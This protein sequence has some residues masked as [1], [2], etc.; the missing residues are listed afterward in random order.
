MGK[1]NSQS[2]SLD[3][4][5]QFRMVYSATAEEYGRVISGG[6]IRSLDSRPKRARRR[7]VGGSSDT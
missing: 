4:I 1:V 3:W 6:V 5:R 2:S 7:T